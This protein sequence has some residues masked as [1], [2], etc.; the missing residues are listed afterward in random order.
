MSAR[1]L[2][3]EIKEAKKILEE[4]NKQKEDIRQQQ[5]STTLKEAIDE[6]IIS[7]LELEA[8]L[9]KIATG[10]VEVEE[11]VKGKPIIRGVSPME[12]IAAIDKIYKKRGSNAPSKIAQTNK[13]G[14]DV[15][16]KITL[17]LND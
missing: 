17:K 6:A 7:D 16:F 1:T 8:V 2:D 9:C 13:D 5:I 10:N 14:D 15:D 11:W 4:R 12:Q 3:N